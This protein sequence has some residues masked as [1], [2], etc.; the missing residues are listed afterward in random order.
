[1]IKNVDIE[2]RQYLWF[3]SKFC[4]PQKTVDCIDHWL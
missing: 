4:G 3:G 2:M 1:M